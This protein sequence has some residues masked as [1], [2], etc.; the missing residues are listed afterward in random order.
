[1]VD[2]KDEIIEEYFEQENGKDKVFYDR[3]SKREYR[4]LVTKYYE[5][6]ILFTKKVNIFEK[7]IED[8]EKEELN[9][10]HII[11]FKKDGKNNHIVILHK[12]QY[13]R[14]LQKIK[15]MD[16]EIFKQNKNIE[17][18]T[19]ELN[20]LKT[21]KN[22]IENHIPEIKNDDN[23]LSNTENNK[24]DLENIGIEK[25]INNN[26]LYIK[27][28]I[29]EDIGIKENYLDNKK[30]NETVKDETNNI[31]LADIDSNLQKTSIG[32]K[33]IYS[34]KD[35][36]T[37]EKA[38]ILIEETI[39]MNN[40]LEINEK[41]NS[42]LDFKNIVNEVYIN[43]F[44]KISTYSKLY[45]YI[46]KKN[47]DHYIDEINKIYNINSKDKKKKL[48]LKIKRCHKFIDSIKNID[49]DNKIV[50]TTLTPTFL[51]NLKKDE[52]NNFIEYIEEYKIRNTGSLR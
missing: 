44:N 3:W 18:L 42:D 26:N 46:L 19:N 45:N 6:N 16:M 28:K 31:N 35:I 2:K 13:N 27:N 24:I 52:F 9:M 8:V 25:T 11:N 21:D 12:N 34:L 47:N 10:E 32:P 40:K 4:K 1:M 17:S 20:K 39:K 5:D 51:I 29:Q 7:T 49:E 50:K 41:I 30:K 23:I 14:L 43:N 33:K 48:N 22:I 36:Y 37:I 15:E 38:N